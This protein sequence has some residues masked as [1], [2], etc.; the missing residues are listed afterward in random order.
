MRVYA[1]RHLLTEVTRYRGT[2]NS[3]T[4]MYLR[5][6]ND[7][8]CTDYLRVRNTTKYL[9]FSDYKLEVGY[10]KVLNVI[11]TLIINSCILCISNL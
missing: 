1:G 2:K 11:N 5:Y 7:N 10:E 9:H 6:L 4:F 3:S 8:L